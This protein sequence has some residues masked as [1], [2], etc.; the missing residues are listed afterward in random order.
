M[1]KQIKFYMNRQA[2]FFIRGFLS[3]LQ[4]VVMVLSFGFVYPQ[5][6]SNLDEKYLLGLL[7]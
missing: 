4:G 6:V 5:W 3:I 1:N 2:Y 7:K